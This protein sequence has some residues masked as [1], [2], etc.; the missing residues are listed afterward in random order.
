MTPHLAAPLKPPSNRWSA[1]LFANGVKCA[2]AGGWLEAGLVA[3]ML[4]IFILDVDLPLGV[5]PEFL[6]PAIV[7]FSL[8]SLR[9]RFAIMMTFSCTGL[10]FLGS[11][12]SP[13]GSPIWIDL[14]NRFIGA[15]LLWIT[16]EL[17]WARREA[18]E[19]LE[20]SLAGLE[21]QVQRRTHE[22]SRAIDS[23]QSE[24]VCRT[25]V[26]RQLDESREQ[27]RHLFDHAPYPMFIVDLETLGF[28]DVNQATV[29]HYGYSRDEL[30]AMTIKD[31]RPR[32]DVPR[33][34]Q[35]LPSLVDSSRIEGPWRHRKKDG[36]VIDVEIGVYSFDYAGRKARLA[37]INDI[38]DSQRAMERVKESEARFRKVF[39]DAPIGMG[40]VGAD[41]RFV[42]VNEALCGLIGFSREELSEQT[43]REI[44]HPDDLDKDVRLVDE[45]FAGKRRS[46]QL[47]KRYLT[48]GGGMIW[49]HLTVTILREGEGKPLHL[50]GMIKDISERKRVEEMRG[51][52]LNGIMTAQEDERQRIAHELHDGIGQTLTALAVGLRSVEDMDSAAGMLV[53][54]RRLREVAANAVDETRRIARG[55]RPSV[56]DD[57]GLEEALR[58]YLRD[59]TV[60]Y[61]IA[62]DLQVG[63]PT[64][65]RLPGMVETVLYRIIQEAMTNTAK[66]SGA[67]HISVVLDHGASMVDA[68]VEDDGRGFQ[69][70]NEQLDGSAGLG[71]Q[72]MYERAKLLGGRVDIETSLGRGTAVYVHLPLKEASQ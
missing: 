42:Q 25:E 69:T 40:I 52:L 56:L 15:V 36:S 2:R 47:E 61:G 10:I 17:G 38:T 41:G 11:A 45:V 62:A 53:Q 63:R 27:Y 50:L 39:D 8:W 66:H 59:Y 4:G 64:T 32:E 21:L 16:L 1:A 14:A 49:G 51:R 58:Q 68:V 60:S 20:E 28:L 35:A 5:A 65:V 37:I 55:L 48:K 19:A 57:L 3:L 44:T 18:R 29:R 13:P 72:G 31:I 23:L 33:L 54:I 9:R 71:I 26:E 24:L 46:Y 43:F 22:L 30:L 70:Q 34:L 6:Y 7:Y 12:L 67:R